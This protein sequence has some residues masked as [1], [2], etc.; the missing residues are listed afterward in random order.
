MLFV[1]LTPH[2][3]VLRAVT[4]TDTVLGPSGQVARV[5]STP[6]EDVILPG[7]PVPVRGAPTWGAVENLPAPSHGI[8]YIVSG[9]V[10]GRCAGRHDVVAPGTGPNDGAI[11]NRDGH[12]VAVTR[13]VRA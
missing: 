7:V 11:R 5:S 12:I 9:L 4:G 6:G 8:M 13:L 1:N 2:P 3:I 10:A